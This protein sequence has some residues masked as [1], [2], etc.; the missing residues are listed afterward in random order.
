MS[1]ANFATKVEVMLN[2]SCWV[3][4]MNMQ[5]TKRQL[6]VVYILALAT[7]TVSIINFRF[8]TQLCTA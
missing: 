1:K 8:S 3:Y 5:E 4:C 6:K 7:D 2:M